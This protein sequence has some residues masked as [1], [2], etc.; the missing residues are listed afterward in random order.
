MT[1][2]KAVAYIRVST[3]M[4]VDGASLDV[5]EK[6][7]LN[8]AKHTL[9]ADVVH[10]YRE[11]GESAK[12]ANRTELIKLL[13]DVQSRKGEI[14]YAIFYDMSRAS[15][16]TDSYFSIV[17]AVLRKNG[18]KLRYATQSGIDESPMG[19]FMETIAIGMAQFEN[20]IKK[21]RVHDSMAERAQQGYWYTQAPIGFIIKV[22]MGD[23]RLA[24]SEG[25]K[26]RV[27]YPKIL[28]PDESIK[29][30]ETMSIS[31][32]LTK[33]LN[34]FAEGDLTESEAHKMA[35]TL[36]VNGKNGQPIT[37]SRFDDLL[38]SPVYAGYIESE[39]LLGKGIIVKAQ[40]DGLV[41]KAVFD[42]IQTILNRGKRDL[43]TKDKELYPLDGIILCEQCGK[44]IH[45]DAPTDG[46]GKNIPRYYCRGGKKCGHGYKSTKADEIHTTFN[47][48]LQDICPTAGTMRL[49]KEILK[50]T[51]TNKLSNV[52]AELEKNRL[53]KTRLD[54]E[55]TETIRAFVNGSISADEKDSLTLKID[56]ERMQ[57]R[58]HRLSLE[59][60]Q[61]LN[62]TTIEYVCNF[63]NKPAKLWKDADLKSKQ[64]LQKMMFPNGLH[65]D[66]KTKKC[67]TEDL[68]PLFSII[69]NKKAPEGSNSDTMV[70]SA[71]IEPALPG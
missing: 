55:K 13:N 56:E 15:R 8:F 41:S 23:G 33:V 31:E 2:E 51:A 5:Q 27:K 34:R 61:T 68:S 18:V 3:K 30:G 35:L 28:V 21:V 7:C 6:A 1:R 59:E 42:R 54:K 29:P 53:A 71:G 65:I 60:Q 45:G 70:T 47:E 11:E 50:R 38:R 32:K 46:S 52:N 25:R 20:D 69:A 22:A 17:K 63:M 10:I 16:E 12:T 36:K 66:L 49:F 19:Q 57:L 40:F 48:L 9:D 14:S 26:N 64:A 4:Q 44:P 39:K 67:R 58:E 24:D 43:T 37:F 62:E